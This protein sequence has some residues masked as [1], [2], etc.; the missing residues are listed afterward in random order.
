MPWI[1]P[2]PW[3]NAK[4][5]RAMAAFGGGLLGI[6]SV[7]GLVA[8]CATVQPAVQ[9]SGFGVESNLVY[10]P[11]SWPEVLRA[12][13]YQ[14]TAAS[15]K[16]RPAVLLIHGGGWAPPDRRQQMKSIAERLVVQGYVVM[17]ATYRFAPKHLHP[18]PVQDLRQALVWL[19]QNAERWNIDPTKVAAFGYS[20]GGHLAALLGAQDATPEQSVSLVVAGGTPTEMAKWS[21]GKL[22][23]QY[24]GGRPAEVPQQYASASPIRFVSARHPPTFIY[25]G[26]LDWVVPVHH[27]TDYQAALSRAGVANEIYLLRGLGHVAAF[28]F[29]GPA[30]EAAISFMN[31]HLGQP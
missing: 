1:N 11:D 4:P 19:R 18:A 13:I 7:V 31:R 14:P 17:N 12:D 21:N 8:G 15:A 29:D 22:V 24:L 3:R 5:L 26:T 10:T 16:A 28:L 23:V 6:A 30:V 2:R 25:H 27:A 20:A 9:P